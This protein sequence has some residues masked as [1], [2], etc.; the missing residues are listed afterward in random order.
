MASSVL[1]ASDASDLF[2]MA[3]V[4]I[5]AGMETGAGFFTLK[6]ISLVE[7]QEEPSTTISERN[8]MFFIRII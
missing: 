8:D 7:L 5:L 4:F 3:T 2:T 1:V 6:D